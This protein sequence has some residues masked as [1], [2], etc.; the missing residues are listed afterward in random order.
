MNIEEKIRR[1]VCEGATVVVEKALKALLEV[2]DLCPVCKAHVQEFVT[3]FPAE[4]RKQL[5][6]LE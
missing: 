1:E 6:E 3:V 2:V 5:K 4:I